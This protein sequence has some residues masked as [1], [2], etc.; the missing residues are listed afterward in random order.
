[1]QIQLNMMGAILLIACHHLTQTVNYQITNTIAY[2]RI[3]LP[4][5]PAH[6]ICVSLED[7][8][9]I[10]HFISSHSLYKLYKQVF[11]AR[12]QLQGILVLVMVFVVYH[13]HVING[14]VR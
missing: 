2:I 6:I 14:T 5:Y 9:V 8:I 4:C 12:C 11:I 7:L 13:C 3:N 1:M 10:E